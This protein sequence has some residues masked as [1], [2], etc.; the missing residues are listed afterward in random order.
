MA[1]EPNIWTGWDELTP[2]ATAAPTEEVLLD[3]DARAPVSAITTI[4][5]LTL[6][7]ATLNTIYF[8]TD[9]S[10]LAY[11]D[12]AGDRHVFRLGLVP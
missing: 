6:A 12:A 8:D 10:A 3:G 5:A 4:P 7:A 2:Q 9:L 1:N 11:K